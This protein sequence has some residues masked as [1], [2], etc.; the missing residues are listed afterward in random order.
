MGE[1][2]PKITPKKPPTKRRKRFWHDARMILFTAIVASALTTCSTCYVNKSQRNEQNRH[3]IDQEKRRLYTDYVRAGA[4]YESAVKDM[5]AARFEHEL[6]GLFIKTTILDKKVSVSNS[7]LNVELQT[8]KIIS[9]FHKRGSDEN[10]LLRQAQRCYG[11]INT[12]LRASRV[13]F[14]AKVRGKA[15]AYLKGDR[16]FPTATINVED[17]RQKLLIVRVGDSPEAIN[18]F[19]QDTGRDWEESI[20]KNPEWKQL[21]DIADAMEQEI[22]EG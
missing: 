7:V 11:E 2:E 17:Y 14:G 13:R 21:S 22:N 16:E 19:I 12:L 3:E 6:D 1:T 9:V 18:Q 20:D 4:A 8:P 10:E 15:T 5:Q